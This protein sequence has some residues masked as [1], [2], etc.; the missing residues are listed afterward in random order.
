M[1]IPIEEVF[2]GIEFK[3]IEKSETPSKESDDENDVVEDPDVLIKS[4]EAD[5]QRKKSSDFN[6]DQEKL[7]KEYDALNSEKSDFEPEKEVEA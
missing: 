7:E 3:T 2:A 1:G 6:S 4:L 5:D